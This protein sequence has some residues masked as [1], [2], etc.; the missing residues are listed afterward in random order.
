MNLPSRELSLAP[1]RVARAR[2]GSSRMLLSDRAKIALVLVVAIFQ[3]VLHLFLL[4][5]WQHYDEP[6]HFEYAWLIANDETLRPTNENVD[7]TMRRDVAA[8]MYEHSFYID[9]PQPELLS[10]GRGIWIGILEFAHPP[11]Y[12]F[13]VSLPLRLVRY[14]DM[15]TQLYAARLVS[16]GLFWLTVGIAVGLMRDLT[17]PGH[18]LRW[19][20]P[21]TL[22]LLPPFA[23]H[24][25]AVNND[26][27]GVFMLSLFMWGAVR[28]VRFGI[29]WQ[30]LLWVLVSALV[31]V[32][33][34]NTAGIA[35]LFVP[36]ALVL[37][38]WAQRGW[39]WRWLVLPTLAGLAVAAFAVMGWGDAA[40]WYREQFGT[41][42]AA[43]TRQHRA[44]APSGEDALMIEVT[45]AD[46][47]RRLVQP[48]LRED[49]QKLRG[50]TVTVGGWI[51]SDRIAEVAGPGI[52]W[53]EATDNRVEVWSQPITVTTTPTF[54][55]RTFAMPDSLGVAYYG[56]FTLPTATQTEPF[57]LYLDGA[58]AIIG[59][60]PAG[61]EPT[62]V[63]NSVIVNNAIRPNLVR[64]GSVEDWWPRLRPWVDRV[65]YQYLRR[66]PSYVLTALFDVQRNGRWLLGYVAPWL[67]YDFF[68]AF[69][70]GH[71]RLGGPNWPLLRYALVGGALLGVGRWAVQAAVGRTRLVPALL[72]LGLVLALVWLNA[73]LWPLPFNWGRIPMT[74]GRYVYAA[75]I[76]MA[77]ALA[78]GWWAVWPRRFRTAGIALFLGSL[79]LL[80]VVSVAVIWNFYQARG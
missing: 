38:W 5:P 42:Q 26:V 11:V 50:Q 71:V 46:A 68:S 34:K 77:L 18:P 56:L 35:L 4:P 80:N 65:L 22:V 45:G 53:D 74:T 7:S 69:A 14:L 76:P 73:I 60:V 8:S 2:V 54:V 20:V 33:T 67:L 16:V 37:G 24:M 64:N 51:W 12:Y 17:R 39:R 21:L 25:T 29:T 3:G 59:E 55:A 61:Q 57:P 47:G 63:G 41:A 43:A 70:W 40:Y 23:S 48:F 1:A 27:G 15:T 79:L 44:E 30:R 31:A 72:L 6:T 66:S 62:L 36:V 28:M 58:F 78:G 19:L 10:D 49:I 9:T 13:L 52:M 75:A 32:L